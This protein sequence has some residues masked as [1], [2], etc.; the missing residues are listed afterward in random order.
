MGTEDSVMSADWGEA[1]GF[2]TGVYQI[3]L[4]W[5]KKVFERQRLRKGPWAGSK[6]FVGILCTVRMGDVEWRCR[7]TQKQE[8]KVPGDCLN[9]ILWVSSPFHNPQQ[10]MPA[11]FLSDVH[12]WEP[13][14]LTVEL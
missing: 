3:D 2:Q 14:V 4:H 7:Y 8:R 10:E 12:I 13:K 1:R 9:N 5:Q 6:E 11:T